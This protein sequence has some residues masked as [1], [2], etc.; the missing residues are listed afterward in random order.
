MTFEENASMTRD[1]G[2]HGRLKRLPLALIVSQ[3]QYPPILRVSDAD[4][5]APFQEAVR[6]QYP[7]A[8]Q[9]QQLQITVGPRGIE[10]V[11]AARQWR[12]SDPDFGWSLVLSPASISLE[13]RGDSYVTFAEMARRFQ[14]AVEQLITTLRPARLDRV[15][16]RYI[17]EIH[18]ERGTSPGAW[19][20]L[21]SDA[22]LAPVTSFLGTEFAPSQTLQEIR[23]NR[24][25]DTAV[26][27]RHGHLPAG[28]TV[29][30]RLNREPSE[31]AFYLLDID[32][33]T[34][35]P[36]APFE[37]AAVSSILQ[38]FNESNW[39]IFRKAV[40]DELFAYFGPEF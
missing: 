26:T 33:G 24:G 30:P 3:V 20:G 17:N 12:F 35:S 34:T 5:I 14:T 1:V 28:S 2:Q 13:G 18:H 8:G 7:L 25:S 22:L 4:F 29:P 23:A 19:A 15:G 37:P 9:E 31:L 16:L 32:H 27:I 40:T 39:L 21:I 6:H 10:P 11:P 38:E 36:R